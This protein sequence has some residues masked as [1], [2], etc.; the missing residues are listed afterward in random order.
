MVNKVQEIS[1][2]NPQK[3]PQKVSQKVFQDKYYLV[4]ILLNVFLILFLILLIGIYLLYYLGIFGESEDFNIVTELPKLETGNFSYEVRQFYPNMK[5]NHNSIS[6]KID[7]ECSD[8][9]KERM[10]EAFK[11]LENKVGIIDFYSIFESPDIEVSCSELEKKSPDKDFFIAG[12]GGA[13]EIIQTG[14]YNVITNG[15]ILLHGNPHGFYECEWPNIELHELL[16]VFGFDHSK[17]ENSL[18]YSYLK[19]C[20]Q[21]LDE[22]IINDLKE[23]YSKENLA[24]LYFKEI[25]GIKKGRYLDFNVSIKNSGTITAENVILS[26]FD[27]GKKVEDFELDNIPFGAGANFYV[28]NFKLR[29]WSSENIEI[30]IDVDNLIKEIDEE[31]NVVEL[32]FD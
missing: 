1:Q 6:Y 4:K 30:V 3:V 22:S 20:E 24:D 23:L 25:L 8:E 2:K 15:I 19:S 27:E 7:S 21:K 12:E 32:K 28:T 17:D 31:N 29:S 5:F 9:K 11:E 26:V 10:L 13:K 14:R 16:H 18:M